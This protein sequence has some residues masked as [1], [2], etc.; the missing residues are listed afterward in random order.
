[1]Y[2]QILDDTLAVSYAQHDQDML[3]QAEFLANAAAEAAVR[4][5][6]ERAGALDEVL[7]SKPTQHKP[8]SLEGCN[9]CRPEA[10]LSGCIIE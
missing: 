6:S 8:P 5:R 3:R 4:E 1:M 9:C 10:G 2:A 7:F